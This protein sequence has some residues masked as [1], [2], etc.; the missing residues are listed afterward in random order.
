MQRGQQNHDHGNQQPQNS[1]KDLQRLLP[2]VLGRCDAGNLYGWSAFS[3][4]RS[5]ALVPLWTRAIFSRMAI[6]SA[7][8]AQRGIVSGARGLRDF[9]GVLICLEPLSSL[10]SAISTPQKLDH[11]VALSPKWIARGSQ[12]CPEKLR[13]VRCSGCLMSKCS[14]STISVSFV[15]KCDR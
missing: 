14:C 2:W 6:R 9:L 11:L 3:P 8:L 13:T 10:L 1:R 12:R 4:L 5:I 15:S 7:L